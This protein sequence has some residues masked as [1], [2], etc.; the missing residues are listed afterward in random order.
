M[1]FAPNKA[2]SQMAEGLQNRCLKLLSHFGS[3]LGQLV[4]GDTIYFTN[5]NEIS[6]H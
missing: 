6:V 2:H 1:D 4:C 3:M 5:F